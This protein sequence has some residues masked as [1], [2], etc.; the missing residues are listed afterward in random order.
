MVLQLHHRI[1][2]SDDDHHPSSTTHTTQITRHNYEHRIQPYQLTCHS[3]PRL[4]FNTPPRSRAHPSPGK[5]S[6]RATKSYTSILPPPPH[7]ANSTAP[8]RTTAMVLRIRLARFGKKHAPF[9]NIVV[10]HARYASSILPKV[11]SPF[12]LQPSRPTLSYLHIH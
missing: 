9:Y 11:S 8:S 6:A 7:R 5:F 3:I 4:N 10:A 2:G 12:Q 1:G